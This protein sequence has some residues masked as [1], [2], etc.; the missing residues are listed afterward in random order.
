MSN[1]S[2]PL[3]SAADASQQAA[4]P[5]GDTVPHL[6]RS[7]TEFIRG[8]V[9]ELALLAQEFDITVTVDPQAEVHLDQAQRFAEVVEGTWK[10]Q[11]AV[12]AEFLLALGRQ[13]RSLANAIGSLLDEVLYDSFFSN[14]FLVKISSLNYAARTL[15]GTANK[16]TITNGNGASG[17]PSF[18]LPDLLA[19]V[20]PEVSNNVRLISTSTPS[21]PSAGS[22][23]MFTRI[24]GGFVEL[25]C[26]G[27]LGDE[28]VLCSKVNI[29]DA[30]T[31][32]K[33]WVQ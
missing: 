11:G 29:A 14:G 12:L 22:M 4:F 25:I 17:D 23:K 2:S 19:L 20:T 32:P 9:R 7:Q 33:N 28:C 8:L 5:T 15:L 13:L 26:R 16:I 6:L 24:N 3:A 21:N 10:P 18:T 30:P 31:L 27:P 1:P